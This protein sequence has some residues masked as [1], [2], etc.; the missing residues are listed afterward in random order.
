[1]KKLIKYIGAILLFIVYACTND[2]MTASPNAIYFESS[3]G[4]NIANISIDKGGILIPIT[5]R[6]AKPM[7]TKS[8]VTVQID[9]KALEQ[10]NKANGTSYQSLPASY[11][12]FN[13]NSFT[14]DKGK[15]ISEPSQLSV[16]DIANLPE[17][18]KYALAI[19]ITGTEGNSPTLDAAKTYYILIDRVLYTSVAELGFNNSIDTKYK[20]TYKGLRAWTMEWRVKAADLNGNNQTLI[21]SYPTEVY[22]RFEKVIEKPDLLQVKIGGLA[23]SPQQSSQPNRWYHLALVYNGS[24]VIWY[25]DGIPAMT[26]ALSASFDFE[27][28]GF[29]GNYGTKQVNEIRFWNIVRSPAEIRNNMYAID[30]ATPGLEGYWKCNDGKGTTIKDYSKNGNDMIAG[31]SFKW[32]SDVRM[33]AE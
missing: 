15:Y 21:Y 33:P 3:A 5:V 17:I 24:S 14:I 16:K 1:M 2:E 31:S 27:S 8:S 20:K 22:T 28:I 23:L 10:Y 6:A 26:N 13:N 32:I 12:T 19:T 29:G 9:P 18:N 7:D 25:I 30:P 11:Y 4:T